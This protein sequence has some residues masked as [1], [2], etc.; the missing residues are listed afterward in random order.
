MHA[1]AVLPVS[2]CMI[3]LGVAFFGIAP[4]QRRQ[5]VGKANIDIHGIEVV[6]DGFVLHGKCVTFYL[7][8]RANESAQVFRKFP[9]DS[10]PDISINPFFDL[11]LG[12]VC[13][14]IVSTYI[15]IARKEIIT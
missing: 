9:F 4:G 2:M 13:S 5:R 8:R 7:E 15:Q 3:D 12:E 11:A 1:A 14:R 6:F 10:H